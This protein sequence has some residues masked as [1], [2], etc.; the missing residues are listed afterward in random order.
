M[1]C[2]PASSQFIWEMGHRATWSRFGG[3]GAVALGVHG[4]RPLMVADGP[5]ESRIPSSPTRRHARSGR[6]AWWKVERGLD[7][8]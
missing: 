2:T 7:S 8:L 4:S 1:A 6:R 5:E 3:G